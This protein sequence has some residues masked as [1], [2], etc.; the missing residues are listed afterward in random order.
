MVC[1]HG[2][3]VFFYLP[4]PG[5]LL[6]NRRFFSLPTTCSW[7]KAMEY[8]ERKSVG[9]RWQKCQ[10]G[11]EDLGEPQKA[12]QEFFF[13]H[14]INNH[15]LSQANFFFLTHFPVPFSPHSFHSPSTLYPLNTLTPP[16]IFL[17]HQTKSR[18]YLMLFTPAKTL[19]LYIPVPLTTRISFFTTLQKDKKIYVP[20]LPFSHICASEC[21]QIN[22]PNLNMRN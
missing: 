9:D 4:Q 12:A 5:S 14:F 17:P 22:N 3:T 1:I 7:L 8:H 20:K 19:S 18:L 13:H 16:F 10:T 15:L 21:N 2:D 6:C 11:E